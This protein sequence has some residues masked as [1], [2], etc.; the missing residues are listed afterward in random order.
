MITLLHAS[1]LQYGRP[2]RPAVG[3]ALQHLARDVEPDLVVVAGDLTQRARAEEFE[4]IARYLEGFSGPGP[5][6]TPGNHDVPLYRVVERLLD[7]Y[8]HWRRWISPELDS[9][10]RVEGVTCVAL[11]S[12]APRR[13][14]IGGRLDP[15]QVAWARAA[16]EAAPEDDARILVTH[17]HFVSPPD[18]E[19]GDPLPGSARILHA[20][21]NMGVDLVLGG[22]LHQTHLSTSRALVAGEGP[23]IP[24]IS[25]GTAASSRGR[26]PETGENSVNLIRLSAE[27]V[28]VR[29]HRFQVGAGVFEE[30]EVRTLA[31][32]AREAAWTGE[33][34]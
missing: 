10:T 22:H 14:V 19:G 33:P 1:D 23:G 2:Y 31:R 8:R 15:A 4:A 30:A 13:A 21:E 12:S 28:E 20:L 34:A 32:R 6:V 18:G 29:V 27:V 11:N 5:V 9:V 25:A 24:L 16:F 17:H 7:P 26:G 3:E